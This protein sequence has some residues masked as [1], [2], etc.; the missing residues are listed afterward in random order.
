MM[1]SRFGGKRGPG[2]RD[3]LQHLLIHG[4]EYPH[5]LINTVGGIRAHLERRGLQGDT[6]D[7]DSSRA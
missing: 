3:P 1:V 7:G 4:F 2:V 5:V 6:R